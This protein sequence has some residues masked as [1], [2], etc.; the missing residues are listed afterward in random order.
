[1]REYHRRGLY[2]ICSAAVSGGAQEGSGQRRGG[3]REALLT[4]LGPGILAGITLGDWL[5]LLWQQRFAVAPSCLPRAFAITL[6]SIK[7]S[8]FR[9]L[10]ERRFGSRLRDVA[11]QPPLFVLGH[12]R[13]GTTHLHN[14]LCLDRRFA[15]PNT[16]QVSF[17]HTFL[18]TEAKS[19]RRLDFFLTGRRPMDDVALYMGSP[20]EDEFA[21]CAST[22]L[23]P[24][25]SWVFPRQRERFEKYLTLRRASGSEVARWKAALDHFLRKLTLKHGRPLVLKSPPHTC[26]IRL[27]L[28]MFPGARFVHIRRHPYDVF[29]STLWTLRANSGWHRLQRANEDDLNSWVIRQYREMYEVYFEERGSIL[30][31]RLHELAFEDLE[32]DP[33]GEIRRLYEVLNLPEL[34]GVAPDVEKY[35]ESLRGYK[36]NVFP[37]LPRELKERIAR[38]WKTCFEAWGYAI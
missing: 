38:E 9:R 10:E 21:L 26:R 31:G 37:E 16:Y 28:G 35:V 27:L 33:L 17:P 6:Q 32:R 15:F 19:A 29:Q 36:K 1:M 25:L 23:S 13:N 2:H 34:E 5:A 7:N 12:W 18:S 30:A 22:L 24:C 4:H 3:W 11:V 8:I 20:Q 14:L